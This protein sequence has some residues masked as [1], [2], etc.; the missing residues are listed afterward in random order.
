LFEFYFTSLRCISLLCVSMQYFYF[1]CKPCAGIF[2]VFAEPDPLKVKWSVPN[3]NSFR[4]S[5]YTTVCA[6]CARLAH[7]S[8]SEFIFGSTISEGRKTQKTEREGHTTGTGNE[9]RRTCEKVYAMCLLSRNLPGNG[10]VL[11]Q[12]YCRLWH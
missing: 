1:F 11:T 3:Y 9:K 10:R 2:F 7:K 8:N 5:K 6:I 4:F 12:T